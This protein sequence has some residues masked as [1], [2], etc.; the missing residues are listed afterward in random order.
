MAH[1]DPSAGTTDRRTATVDEELKN[2]LQ[3]P[4][5]G[6]VHAGVGSAHRV[7]PSVL[8]LSRRHRCLL[9]LSTRQH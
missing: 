9:V 8:V 3:G 7:D 2:L 6:V 5:E 4:G 1:C